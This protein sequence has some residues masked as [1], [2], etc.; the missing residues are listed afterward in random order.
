[1]DTRIL[2]ITQLIKLG[3]AAAIASALVR[4]RE[5]KL[6]VF[7]EDRTRRQKIELSVA[8]AVLFGLGVIT[9][10][11]VKNF[12]AADLSLEGVLLIGVISGR[13]GGTLGGMIVAAP[14]MWHAEWAALPF[15][16]LAGLLAGELRNLARNYEEIWSFSPF[17][18][19]NI[20]RSIRQMLQL[21]RRPRIDWQVSFF[22]FSVVL[23][24]AQ[25]RLAHAFP[26]RL[27]VVVS[28][29]WPVELAAYATTVACVAIPLKIWNSA[30]MEMKLQEQQQ[31]L[32]Q[33]RL[34]AL[35]SQINPHFLFNTLNTVSSLVRFD[36]DQ[37]RRLIVKL[38]S[39]LRRLLKSHESFVHLRE[40]VEFIDDYL[41]IEVVRFGRDKLRV[42][43]ELDP[44]TLEVLVPSMLL[45]PLVENSIKHG[46]APKVDGGS[47][48]LRSRMDAGKLL[49]QVED[50]GVGLGATP[51]PDAAGDG[52]GPSTGIGMANVAGRLK[53]LYGNAAHMTVGPGE[54]AGTR[55]VLR[56]PIIE[57]ADSGT[58]TAAALDSSR[59][60]Q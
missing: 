4:S 11:W 39:I 14:A 1:M 45:Q 32:M 43:K 53:V 37:A 15:Y 2:L 44:D 48:T 23:R 9:R 52:D 50:D 60:P 46:L 36:P 57:W 10:L 54:H 7:V 6:R 40:E 38:A 49:I 56:L 24:F 55:V 17:I 27:F 29:R 22:M 25:E 13:L 12:L 16:S 30:R 18:D 21:L 20:Y 26:G 35:Q 47:I 41:D 59:R 8:I 19:L 51:A 28:D 58:E 34:E 5:F 33:A 42:V 31:Q 3:A